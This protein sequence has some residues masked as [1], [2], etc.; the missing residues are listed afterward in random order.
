[1]GFNTLKQRLKGISAINVT[2]FT[3]TNNE[4]NRACLRQNI[5]YLLNNDIDV[6][7]P[8]GNTGEFYSMT[9][10]ESQRVI[11]TTV[12]EVKRHASKQKDDKDGKDKDTASVVA[13]VGYDHQTAIALSEFAQEAGADG[14]M[15]HQ[16]VHPYLTEDGL[17]S[18]YQ[19]IAS[20]V[21]LGVILYVKSNVL[22]ERGFD[23]L[24]ETNNIVG[25]KYALPDPI[26]FAELTQKYRHWEIIWVCGLAES[27]APF[28]Y[29]AGG[30]GFTSGLVNVAPEKSTALL[31][32]LRAGKTQ[33]ILELW[34]DIK[35][36]EDLRAKYDNGNNVTVVKEAMNLAG[37]ECGQVRP[38]ISPL[39]AHDLE[40]LKTILNKW[41]KWQNRTSG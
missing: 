21:D 3:G 41:G 10:E 26:T 34:L 15:I 35:P 38:P 27:W 39:Q 5:R 16:P 17:V 1:M 19:Q 30:Q 14:I 25:I 40:V 28:F 23:Q 33:D 36:F 2:P 22:T 24:Q 6:I 8:C 18:Y 9:V 20:S 37:F 31:K 4:V 29:Q 7:V 11:E 32:A 12:D 13:G